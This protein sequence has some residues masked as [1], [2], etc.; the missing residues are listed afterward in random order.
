MNRVPRWLLMLGIV[1]IAALMAFPLRDTIYETVVVPLAFVMWELGLLYH[2]LSQTVWWWLIISLVLLI[3]SF[4][5]LP[6]FDLPHRDNTKIRPKRGA[7]ED[8]AIWL[9]R[10]KSGV[11][12]KWLIA[13]RLGKLAYQI[14][15]HR[16]SGR[17]RSVFAPL[18]G[19]DWNPSKE[20]QTY[21]E[22]GLHGSFSD[23]PTPRMPLV[24]PPKT[25]LDYDVRQAVEFLESQVDNNHR[26][27][28]HTGAEK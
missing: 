19:M 6:E 20:L 16:E 18:I 4:S 11:Y 27:Q 24:V 10:S 23:F 17:P 9:G 1:I 2:S 5:L 13:N 26:P 21:L 22:T 15:L 25:P 28:N 8:L 7:V 12:F 14:L 3:L